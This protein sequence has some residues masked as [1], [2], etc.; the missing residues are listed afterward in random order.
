[1]KTFGWFALGMLSAFGGGLI[2]LL[3][4][5]VAIGWPGSVSCSARSR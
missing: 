3:A 2:A 1:M 5:I 4:L